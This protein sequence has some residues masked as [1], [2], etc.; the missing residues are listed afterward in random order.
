M[1]D[2]ITGR[3]TATARVGMP[4]KRVCVTFRAA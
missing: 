2:K 3:P 4:L 1:N